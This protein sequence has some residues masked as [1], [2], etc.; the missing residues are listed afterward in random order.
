MIEKE[1]KYKKYDLFCRYSTKLPPNIDYFYIIIEEKEERLL[2]LEYVNGG[3]DIYDSNED[4]VGFF[5][6]KSDNVLLKDLHPIIRQAMDRYLSVIKEA[7]QE[8][9]KMKS[10]IRKMIKNWR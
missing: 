2:F 9:R 1:F 5:L 3:V 7:R 6:L 10:K 4:F 8:Q